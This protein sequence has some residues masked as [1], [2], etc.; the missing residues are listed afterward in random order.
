MSFKSILP[1]ISDELFLKF[2]GQAGFC[3]E[4]YFSMSI[5][6]PYT[7]LVCDHHWYHGLDSLAST[8]R[9]I[10]FCLLFICS[11][12][13]SLI[14]LH[15]YSFIY[16]SHSCTYNDGIDEWKTGAESRVAPYINNTQNEARF[17]TVPGNLVSILPNSDELTYRRLAT[18]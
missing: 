3:R 4:P 18:W 7:A 1:L 12:I 8:C 6:P 14:Y 16:S 2:P 13:Y 9:L 15:N 10:H 11:L 5:H 17:I